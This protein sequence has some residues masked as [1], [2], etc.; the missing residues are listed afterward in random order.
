MTGT[1]YPDMIC[2][3]MVDTEEA[4][5]RMAGH[6]QGGRRGAPPKHPVLAQV[7]VFPGWSDHELGM[8]VRMAAEKCTA[9]AMADEVISRAVTPQQVSAMLDR[10]QE[11]LDTRPRKRGRAS[12]RSDTP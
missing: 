7:E 11:Y 2:M 12:G 9:S 5:K 1:R 6:R 3:S 4:K 10:V 8:V